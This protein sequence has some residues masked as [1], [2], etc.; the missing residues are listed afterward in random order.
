MTLD[1]EIKEL[2]SKATEDIMSQMRQRKATKK[3]I[4]TAIM[5]TLKSETKPKKKAK[6]IKAIRV[7]FYVSESSD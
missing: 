7:P 5:K 1:E 3:Q 6:S 2:V 4:Y